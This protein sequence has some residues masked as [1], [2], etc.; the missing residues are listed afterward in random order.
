M[1]VDE[2]IR[3]P[4]AQIK[5]FITC[6]ICMRFLEDCVTIKE[7]LHSCKLTNIYKF[8]DAI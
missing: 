7:C 6:N 5:D 4:I 2:K 1:D 3:L 8:I